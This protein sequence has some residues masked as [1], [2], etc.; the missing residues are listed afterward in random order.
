MRVGVIGECMVEMNKIEGN[1]YIQTYGGD[2]FNFAVYFK[3]EFPQAKVEYITVLGKDNF[4]KNMIEFIKSEDIGVEYI[5]FLENKNAGLY[6]VDTHNGERSFT[7]YRDTSAAKELFRTPM[8]KRLEEELLKFDLIY[9]S[10]ITLAIMSKEGRENLF[11]ILKK[12]KQNGT[13]IA[14]DSNYRPRLYKNAQKAIKIYKQALKFC[15]IFLPSIDDERLLLGDITTDEVIKHAKKYAKEIV[16]KCGAHPIV[17]YHKKTKL[18]VIE[19]SKNIV[20]TTAAGD[21][22]NGVYLASRMQKQSIKNSIDK[23]SL[24]ASRVIGIKGAIIP[25]EQKEII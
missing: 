17:Y 15:D 6:M 14:Y 11:S 16:I 4:S 21:S 2:T 5:D 9:F 3:R 22:F 7:Y 20:D 1:K 24:M 13:I 10:A 23:A 25:K 8:L 12:A 19:P 18:Y